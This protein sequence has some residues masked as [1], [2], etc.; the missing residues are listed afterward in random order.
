[1][2]KKWLLSILLIS[3]F[4]LTVQKSHE[5]ASLAPFFKAERSIKLQNF[6]KARSQVK[7]DD[8][9]L[10]KLW[11]SIL[12][13]RSA[14]LSKWMKERYKLLGLNHLFTPSGFHI[15]AVLL[16]FM[17]LLKRNLHQLLLLVGLGLALFFLPGLAALKRM[18]LIKSHQ[19]IFGLIPGFVVALLLDVLF[20]SFQEGAL[21]FTYSFLFIGI[22]YSGL[23]GVGLI[24]WFFF[25]QIILAYFQGTD[26][27]PLLLI[28][29][30]IVNL[31]FGVAMPLLFLLAI[32]LWNWQLHT[33]IFILKAL[34]FPIDLFMEVS[35]FIP[36]LEVNVG[37]LILIAFIL[38]KKWKL[39]L[40]M[41]LFLSFSLNLDRQKVPGLP[42]KEYMAHGS[43]IRTFYDEKQVTVYK[44][45]GICRMK[46]VRGWWWE[47][48]SPRR[49]SNHKRL[50]KLSYPS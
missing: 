19:K 49:G 34:Q 1:M 4:L 40:G 16:P 9:E 8:L 20:G 50:K 36:R 14:P 45:D 26:I 23:E 10:L 38:F 32:P 13:G 24:F 43:V 39:M 37:L 25:A 42:A 12:T 35:Q 47:N 46:L 11:E 22:I 5:L 41:C 6:A 48:C 31:A 2:N 28:F 21:G 44:N 17:K 7:K 3:L 29:S 15:S 18:V 27:S 33:G 30:P